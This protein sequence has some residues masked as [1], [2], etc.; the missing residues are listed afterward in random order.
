MTSPTSSSASR[1]DLPT[2]VGQGAVTY[3]FD[4]YDGPGGLRKRELHPSREQPG[5]LRHD[6]R[7]TIV[8]SLTLNLTPD[9]TD[10]VDVITDRV[11][12]RM[13]LPDGSEHPLGRYIFADR[14][15]RVDTGGNFS[16]CSLLDEMFVVAQP[17]TQSFSPYNVNGSSSPGY[18]NVV[19]AITTLLRDLPV[20]VSTEPS[21]Y[22][23]S[24]TWT[25]GTDRAKILQDLCVQGG[26]LSPWFDHTST[27]RIVRAF[28]PAVQVP[29]FNLDEQ[30]RVYR[31]SI[32]ESSNLIN[33]PNRFVV[34]SNSGREGVPVVGTYNVPAS[35]P[36]SVERR[37]FVIPQVVNVQL[38]VNQS[39]TEVART[40]GL[41][42][43][44]VEAVEFTTPPDPRHDGYDVIRWNGDTWLEVAWSLNLTSA[45][46]MQHVL[47]RAY[48]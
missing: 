9:D 45:G 10:A 11:T 22:V 27:L 4:L 39:P 36:H 37:G 21:P 46:P 42:S 48:L 7:Q 8:R 40:I 20:T 30:P 5:T 31:D 32:V 28:D 6:T 43:G 35:A 23:T 25:P 44:V 14:P 13:V 1:F 17:I 15:V 12:V 41:Q 26:Y 16:S 3:R 18:A 24:T 34:V 47:R 33:A 19:T 38:D 2:Y 29:T